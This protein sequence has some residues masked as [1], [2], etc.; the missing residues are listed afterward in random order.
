MTSNSQIIL[1]SSLQKGSR[2]EGIPELWFLH[3]WF[4]E[5]TGDLRGLEVV[6]TWLYGYK[7]YTKDLYKLMKDPWRLRV[8]CIIHYMGQE[9]TLSSPPLRLPQ[10]QVYKRIQTGVLLSPASHPCNKTI[11]TRTDSLFSHSGSLTL[12]FLTHSMIYFV[13]IQSYAPP[14]PPNTYLSRHKQEFIL[15]L[16]QDS[17][18]VNHLHPPLHPS[19]TWSSQPR[20]SGEERPSGWGDVTAL[21]EGLCDYR[22][23][24]R[25][26][27]DQKL[28]H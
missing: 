6:L 15:D 18:L 7:T 17:R 25:R 27:G 16:W 11:N 13:F 4:V 28:P 24:S 8:I 20:S 26:K 12:A 10:A 9:L 22:V 21:F 23:S 3:L 19:L 14:P 2:S 1:R 5:D